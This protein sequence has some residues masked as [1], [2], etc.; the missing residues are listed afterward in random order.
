MN[1]RQFL[2]L[3]V[4]AG[5]PVSASAVKTGRLLPP[6][7]IFD[8]P[9]EKTDDWAYRTNYEPASSDEMAT[10]A[11]LLTSVPKNR[12][13]LEIVQHVAGW[14]ELNPDKEAFNAEWIK[15]NRSNPVIPWFFNWT[16]QKPCDD[17][18]E[19]WCAAFMAWAVNR[20]GRMQ[21]RAAEVS[22]WITTA[23]DA[24]H[25]HP[26]EEAQSGD[27]VVMRYRLHGGCQHHI[28]V[29]LDRNGLNLNIIGG[30]Q[31]GKNYGGPPSVREE[32]LDLAAIGGQCKVL[33][34]AP[35]AILK[36]N[37]CFPPDKGN[38]FLADPVVLRNHLAPANSQGH[39]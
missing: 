38:K 21:T 13:L 9:A 11:K 20:S 12:P 14:S 37:E 34:D 30:N 7:E 28:S 18:A 6:R 8:C 27:I 25:L 29:F 1:R 15:S 5:L 2:A 23:R 35:C 24:N 39:E 10:A 22:G 16:D 17:Q 31:K 3:G 36:P 4:L 32:W 26:I 33:G 19:N